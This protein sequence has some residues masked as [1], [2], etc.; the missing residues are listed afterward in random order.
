[1]YSDDGEMD[2]TGPGQH[3]VKSVGISRV[4]TSVYITKLS[5][6]RILHIE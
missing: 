6:V 4:D 5:V 3:P 1:M 2:R